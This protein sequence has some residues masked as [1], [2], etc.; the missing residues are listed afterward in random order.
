MGIVIN[1]SV[2]STLLTY[3]GVAIGYLNLVILYPKYFSTTE[4]GLIRFIIQASV[5]M[6]PLAMMGMS[7]I[8]IRFYPYFKSSESLKRLLFLAVIVPLAGF[9]MVAGLL[10]YFEDQV[11]HL[12]EN[13]SP[14]V[15]EYF[16]LVYPLVFFI[17]M[18]TVWHSYAR[19]LL[20]IVIPN[21][22]KEVF[23][24]FGIT[25]VL[26][27]FGY[28]GLLTFGQ[29]LILIIVVYGLAFLSLLLYVNSL[30]R[31]K[32]S[33]SFKLTTK[34]MAGQ[35][36]LFGFVSLL[37]SVSTIVVA[38][39]DIIMLA[40]L[41]GLSKTGI[42]G[43]AFYIGVA[44]E[45]PRRSISQISSPLVSRAWKEGKIG[46]IKE[47][48]QKTSINQ[49][50]IGGL[51]FVGIWSNVGNVFDI[52]P[53]GERF[54]EGTWVI[55]FIGMG[56]FI[57]MFTGVNSEILINSKYYYYNLIS[58][59]LLALFAVIL[60]LILIPEYGIVGAAIAAAISMLLFNLLKFTFLLITM[61]IQP[62][63]RLTMMGFMLLGLCYLAGEYLPVISSPYIDLAYRSSI[64]VVIFIAG[65]YLFRL[66]VDLRSSFEKVLARGIKYLG[67]K[68]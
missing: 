5:L 11:F 22:L 64:I 25:I 63:T 54:V 49:L 16:N 30:Q 17:L 14:L 44:V 62:F 48:Y 39:I 35:I 23:V 47:L 65:L 52:M 37:T 19:S 6:V 7:S 3:F 24:R 53:N 51:L 57:D 18:F 41:A 58:I 12:F 68:L 66:N 67:I 10:Y 61:K 8:L 9:G 33:P 2:R 34:S 46:K 15:F 43:I 60:N 20:K 45:L 13:Q 50:L 29:V 28:F 38:N 56:K 40:S 32:I 59:I 1:Q 55:F 27:L 31:I 26:L 21:F 4:I 36:G 42:Y